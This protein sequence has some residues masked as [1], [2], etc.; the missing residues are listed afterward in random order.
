MDKPETRY[1][2]L[3]IAMFQHDRMTGKELAKALG[4]S[5]KTVYNKLRGRTEWTLSEIKRIGDMFPE[6]T[7]DFLFSTEG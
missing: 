6:Y 3:E 5:T 4:I 7:I 1:I 2:N